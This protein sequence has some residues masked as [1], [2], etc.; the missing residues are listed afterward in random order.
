MITHTI[1]NLIFIAMKK[2]Y[3]IAAMA[4]LAVVSISC[5]K[6]NTKPDAPEDP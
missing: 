4:A 5:N 2:F 1:T 3:V 6:N